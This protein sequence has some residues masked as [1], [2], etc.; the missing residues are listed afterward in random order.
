[1]AG[2][3]IRFLSSIALGAGVG[4]LYDIFRILRIAVP[5]KTFVIALED[6]LYWTMAAFVTF[7]FFF[8]SDKGRIRLFLLIGEAIGFILWYF[9]LG[10]LLIRVAKKVIAVVKWIFVWLYR[11]FIRPFVLLFGW[12]SGFLIAAVRCIGARIKKPL[13]NSNIPLQRQTRLLYN[14]RKHIG[15]KDT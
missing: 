3:T 12:I 14:L 15:G 10:A 1:M 6:M 11:I 2:Q 13:K 7:L 9:T 5:H 8:C 4:L